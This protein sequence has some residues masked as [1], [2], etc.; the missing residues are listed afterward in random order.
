[1]KQR[2]Y[3]DEERKARHSAQVLASKRKAEAAKLLGDDADL[4]SKATPRHRLGLELPEDVY[5]DFIDTLSDNKWTKPQFIKW[6][7]DKFKREHVGATAP[8]P[9]REID[10]LAAAIA[11][12][13]VVNTGNAEEYAE[14][15]SAATAT[16]T[17]L[18]RILAHYDA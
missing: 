4:A 10:A 11:R 7:L 5:A 8:M 15:L 3:T 1:M 14:T 18:T 2:I 13:A 6:A 12:A 9:S 16:L 17:A